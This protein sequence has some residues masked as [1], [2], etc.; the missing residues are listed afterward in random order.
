MQPE[1]RGVRESERSLELWQALAVAY[2]EIETML[3][4]GRPEA[5]SIKVLTARILT[6]E[7]ELLTLVGP[8][9]AWRSDPAA[10]GELTRLWASA[11]RII[12]DLSRR[13]PALV[14]AA[15]VAR[16]GVGEELLRVG[17]RRRTTAAYG[18]G[19]RRPALASR[20]V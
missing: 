7:G 5:V 11:D 13:H 2:G 12:E 18:S 9:A 17:E 10:A 14:R 20:M 15:V 8:I 4:S 1:G 16:D 6:L 3:A 19:A